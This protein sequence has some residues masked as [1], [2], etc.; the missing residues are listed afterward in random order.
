MAK[1][2]ELK[3]MLIMTFIA[4]VV[5][6]AILGLILAAFIKKEETPADLA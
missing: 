1:Q 6:N 2:F 4:G 3:R 5:T